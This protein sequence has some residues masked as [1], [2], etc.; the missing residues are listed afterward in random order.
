M[1]Y[2]LILLVLALAIAPLSH[3][4]PSK[5]QRLV[6]RMREYAAVNGLFVEFRDLPANAERQRVHSERQN[7]V[8][9]YGKR[10]PPSRDKP[11]SKL[12][13]LPG[14]EGWVGL[15][16]RQPA[17]DVCSQLPVS[18]QA[19]GVDESSCGVYWQ[20]QGSEA[21]VEKIVTVVAEWAQALSTGV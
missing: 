17:P 19:L 2:L 1:K 21:D 12:A 5:R 7:Q 18:I 8:I 9:Y 11:R 3:F 4:F 16:H 6:A 13:W 10:L 15:G 14:E 20:E